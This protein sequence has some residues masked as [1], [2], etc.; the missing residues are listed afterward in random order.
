MAD[1]RADPAEISLAMDQSGGTTA[2]FS[3]VELLVAFVILS[4]GLGVAVQT[5]AQSATGLKRA[6]GYEE[7]TLLVRRLLSEELPR[8][9]NT[10]SGGAT[11]A[12]GPSWKIAIRPV[13]GGKSQGSVS[14]SIEVISGTRT[15]VYTTVL[16]VAT[17]G[18]P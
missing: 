1:G 11:E 18:T 16:P 5:I 12:T 15:A 2:G 10:Y 13:A 4:L 3:T 6:T 8:L 9:V 14:A 7:E 17:G